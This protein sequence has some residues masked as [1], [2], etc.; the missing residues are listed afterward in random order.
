MS[1]SLR[2]ASLVPW[3]P[4]VLRRRAVGL[5][6]GNSRP[7]WKTP[8]GGAVSMVLGPCNSTVLTLTQQRRR[9]G[10]RVAVRLCAAAAERQRW[11]P[12]CK[13][14]N[15]EECS[16]LIRRV[17]RRC[18][19]LVRFW[20]RLRAVRSEFLEAVEHQLSHLWQALRPEASAAV[21]RVSVVRATL[22]REVA[23]QASLVCSSTWAQRLCHGGPPRCCMRSR[24]LFFGVAWP[25]C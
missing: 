25:K 14:V 24:I 21:E 10:A 13:S 20:A 3:G 17:G 4:W 8:P 6:G 1:T 16:R 2:V 9:H 7:P 18:L 11:V 23:F 19:L 15:I 5:Q 12:R 22:S